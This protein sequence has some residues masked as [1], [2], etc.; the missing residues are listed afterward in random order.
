MNQNSLRSVS[1]HYDGV[2]RALH[3]GMALLILIV[4]A[5][6]LLVDAFPK[7]WEHG[8][9]ETHKV[10]GVAILLL[11]VLRFGWR[12]SHR[13]P[14]SEPINPLIDR[15]AGL[16]HWGLYGLMVAVPV[17]GLVYAVLRGQ[18]IDF[19]LFSLAP[20]ME[21][22]RELGRTVRKVHELAAYAL[23]A[24]AGIH[25]LA[26]IWHHLIRKDGTLRRMLPG[27]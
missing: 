6:G 5:M 26:A 22:N 10:L 20:I 2:A 23:I 8:I 17:V 13:P 21:P 14:A 4:F 11:V 16:A 25:A 24:L 7:T 1:F 3:W 12:L 9:V 27:L 18:G 15:G 19:G